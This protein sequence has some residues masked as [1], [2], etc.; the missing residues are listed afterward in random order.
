MQ[1]L[2]ICLAVVALLPSLL[3]AKAYLTTF[4]TAEIGP[5]PFADAITYLAA[6]ERLNVGHGLYAFQPG[7]RP[8]FVYPPGSKSPLLSP[9]PI[10]A[11]W[12]ILAAVPFGF[13]L[14]VVGAWLSLLGTMAYLV[15][16]IGW[17]AAA[18]CALFYQPIGEQL[19]VANMTSFFPALLV[20]SWQFRTSGWSAS[21]LGAIAVLKLAPIT[22]VGW[23]IRRPGRARWAIGTAAILALA[24]ALAAGPMSYGDYLGVATS[25][26]SSPFSLATQLGIPWLS[27]AILLAGFAA[28]FLIRN[29]ALAFAMA[30]TAFV[31]GNPAL[32]GASLVP[33]IA[34]LAPL[35]DANSSGCSTGGRTDGTRG[36]LRTDTTERS[37]AS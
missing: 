24:G 1:T 19:A 29:D 9:P 34:V 36:G 3:M 30:I 23:A 22:T 14:W 13:E 33:L 10:A 8:L 25:S 31:A 12:R 7:D 16:R 26:I 2:R 35:L 15:F 32:Y 18:V 28:G 21:A 5:R 20:V 37:V 17:P 4:A 6:G 11:P 27:V